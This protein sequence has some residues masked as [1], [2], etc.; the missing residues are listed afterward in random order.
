[1]KVFFAIEVD[2]PEEDHQRL[3]RVLRSVIEGMVEYGWASWELRVQTAESRMAERAEV[4]AEARERL[5]ILG[6]PSETD[7]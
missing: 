1:M 4:I 3:E 6:P 2:A 5:R 7:T